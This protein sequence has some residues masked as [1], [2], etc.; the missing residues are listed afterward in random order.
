[1]G[2]RKNAST[3]SATEKANFVAAVHDLKNTTL[4]GH[5]LSMYD[6]F[7]AEHLSVC[8]IAYGP[9][10]GTNG[11]HGGPAFCPW[12]REFIC[13]FE[14]ALQSFDPSVS[15]PYWNWNSGNAP[16]TAAVFADD[17]LGGAGTGPGGAVQTGPFTVANGW[18]IH[19][20]LTPKG[21]GNALT[22]NPTLDP[23]TLPATAANNALN[24]TNY[25]IFQ[26]DLEDNSHNEVHVWVGG[27]MDYMTS[28]NDPV[29]FLHHANVDRLW[30]V[31]QEKYPGA[32]NYDTPTA[33]GP[34]GHK[35]DD[36]MWPWDGGLN[37]GGSSP[38]WI[39]GMMDCPDEDIRPYLPT[40]GAMDIVTPRMVVDHA[41]TCGRYDT[42]PPKLKDIIK[43][44][45][46]E[47]IKLETKEFI[48]AESKD[49]SKAEVKE[50]KEKD[51]FDGPGKNWFKEFK[52][53][54]EKDKDIFEGPIWQRP[55][56]STLGDLAQRITVIEAQLGHAFIA[57]EERPPV[58][59]RITKGTGE[60][61]E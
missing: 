27:N 56:D 60:K 59:R 15:L 21:M 42:D 5:A 14:K 31:W 19:T 39:T 3:L 47:I 43:S 45:T 48:K 29:F 8:Y 16:D 52:E 26:P 6:E 28:P 40:F 20:A 12:H 49:F 32:A 18:K 38:G 25:N 30:A 51:L 11:A 55:G 13:R 24:D 61:V 17:F 33:Y 23:S 50:L 44:E 58:G 54:K 57:A 35:I 10:A 2:Y 22:R 41:A 4:Q 46:K 36:R 9:A 1:M 53:L 37:N 34:Y 7:V